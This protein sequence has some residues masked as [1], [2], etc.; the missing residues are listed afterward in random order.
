MMSLWLYFFMSICLFI[1]LSIFSSQ[2][3]NA[4]QFVYVMCLP[5]YVIKFVEGEFGLPAA[6]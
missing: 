3:M 6:S 4:S 1:Y 5:V 2:I